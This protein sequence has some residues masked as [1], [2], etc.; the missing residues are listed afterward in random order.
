MGRPIGVRAVRLRRAGSTIRY[1]SAGDDGDEFSELEPEPDESDTAPTRIRREADSSSGR[2]AAIQLDEPPADL[3]E[4][5]EPAAAPRR[6]RGTGRRA[7]DDEPPD[8]EAATNVAP[9]A[10]TAIHLP[11]DRPVSGPH[12]LSDQGRHQVRSVL[13]AGETISTTTCPPR[14]TSSTRNS[15]VPTGSSR[16]TSTVRQIFRMTVT[17]LPRTAA[18]LPG[19]GS[20]AGLCGISHTWP[21]VRLNVFTVASPSIIAATMSPLSAT[22]C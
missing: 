4:P 12:R 10:Q 1:A 15:P 6:R 14:S 13:G 8:D 19:I 22:F 7:A 16:P 5:D 20:K 18:S 2:H 21:R 3:H 17:T 11:L 9:D